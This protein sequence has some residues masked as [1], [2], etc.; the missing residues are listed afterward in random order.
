[1]NLSVCL[2]HFRTIKTH[3]L[4][5]KFDKS[6]S[7]TQK[8]IYAEN[9]EVKG[10]AASLMDLR[11]EPNHAMASWRCLPTPKVQVS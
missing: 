9:S 7:G 11:I 3:L 8:K 1:M 6:L 5:I 10:D 4:I 2:L